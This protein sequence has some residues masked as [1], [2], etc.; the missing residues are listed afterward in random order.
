MNIAADPRRLP[1]DDQK[2]LA[3]DFE[4]GD[5]VNHV[6]SGFRQ[7]PCAADIVFFVK[8]RFDLKKYRHLFAVPG[9][10]FQSTHHRGIAADT[11][12]GLLDRQ[13]IGIFRRL[14]Q[15]THHRIK[16]FIRQMDHGTTFAPD[17]FDHTQIGIEPVGRQRRLRRIGQMGSRI[18]CSQFKQGFQI[19]R[20]IDGIGLFR[21][22]TQPRQQKIPC[23][24][25]SG[26]RDLQPD[27]D[28]FCFFL[29]G[30]LH[31]RKNIVNGFFV[32]GKIHIPRHTER[33]TFQNLTAV[34]KHFQIVGDQFFHRNEFPQIP[35]I[36]LTFQR[37][38]P[39]NHCRSFQH[40]KA[41]LKSLHR[42]FHQTHQQF[43]SQIRHQGERV[44]GV[45]PDGCENRKDLPFK[46]T[47]RRILFRRSKIAPRHDPDMFFFQCGQDLIPEMSILPRHKFPDALFQNTGQLCG[48]TGILLCQ[49]SHADHKK[50]IQIAAEDRQKFQAFHQGASGIGRLI[51]DAA[52]EFQPTDIAIDKF[53]IFHVQR[54]TPV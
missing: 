12:Q 17:I 11:I 46:H 15:Q 36:R 28:P 29:K 5:P 42:R 49:S 52:V 34:E 30:D 13:Y 14:L 26:S 33:R 51:E 21:C 6:G 10:F 47:A 37:N 16:R 53:F 44:C 39:G 43:Q 20:A 2:S 48:D 45:D 3:V 40:G 9:G 23:F 27:H 25:G 31:F 18:Q 50:F 41:F 24:C 4:F 19:Q 7:F 35:G 38:E 8:T 54:H 1:A 22:G 32:D